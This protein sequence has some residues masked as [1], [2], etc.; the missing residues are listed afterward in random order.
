VDGAVVKGAVVEGAAVGPDDVTMIAPLPPGDCTVP[1]V[2]MDP[3][4]TPVM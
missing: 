4:P 3:T 1:I 2:E